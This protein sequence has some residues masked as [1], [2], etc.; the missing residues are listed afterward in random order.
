VR[1]LT[2]EL[3]CKKHVVSHQV[4]ADSLHE[5][6]YRL[7]ANRKTTEGSKHP[8]RNAQFERLNGKVKWSLAGKQTVTAEDSE[9]G[10]WFWT[11]RTAGES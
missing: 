9:G 3:G 10:N 5:L 2:A 8:D 4:V 11:L 1:Q 6:G 7:Q